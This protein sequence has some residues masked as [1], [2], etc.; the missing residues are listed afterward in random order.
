MKKFYC[1]S[2]CCLYSHIDY[3]CTVAFP[4]VSTYPVSVNTKKPEGRSQNPATQEVEDSCSK[5]I[6]QTA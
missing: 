1:I 2:R 3:G 6:R 5:T 4:H